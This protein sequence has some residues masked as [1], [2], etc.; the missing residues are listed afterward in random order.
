MRLKKE[1]L[2]HA[3]HVGFDEVD[4]EEVDNMLTSHDTDLTTDELLQMLKER[5]ED[6]E[7]ENEG[8]DDQKEDEAKHLTAKKLSSVRWHR[9]SVADSGRQRPTAGTFQQ[10][11][12]KRS[13]GVEV[14]L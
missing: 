4:E 12:T 11:F 10:R 7:R 14:L 9:C 1:M 5:E 13:T 8:D 3:K 6:A 2:D